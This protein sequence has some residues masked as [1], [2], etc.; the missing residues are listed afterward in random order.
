[1]PCCDFGTQEKMSLAWS[2]RLANG[3]KLVNDLEVWLDFFLKI[4]KSYI[5]YGEWNKVKIYKI[6]KI[7]AIKYTGVIQ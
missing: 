5:I 1:M 6:R 4:I 3:E 2:P 7:R